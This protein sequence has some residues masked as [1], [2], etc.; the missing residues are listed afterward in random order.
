MP[1]TCRYAVADVLGGRWVEAYA[2]A[3]DPHV[4]MG[5]VDLYFAHGFEP[6]RPANK[7]TIVRRPL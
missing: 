6:Y 4:Y 3:A 7:R 5:G 1:G 2:H